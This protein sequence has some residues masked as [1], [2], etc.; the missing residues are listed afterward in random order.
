MKVNYFV[1]FKPC[2]SDNVAASLICILS[3]VSI[4]GNM[5]SANSPLLAQASLN[6]P[7]RTLWLKVS[8]RK[9][10]TNRTER[11]KQRWCETHK[12]SW[13]KTAT[14]LPHTPCVQEAL[15]PTA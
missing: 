3:V 6:G 9:G 2:P 5:G 7:V 14:G 15:P 1:G 11:S 8:S 10:E 13:L 4:E 12:T